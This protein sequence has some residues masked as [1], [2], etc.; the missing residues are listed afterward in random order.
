MSI[1]IYLEILPL[2]VKILLIIVPAGF[3]IVSIMMLMERIK[4]IKG[5]EEDDLSKY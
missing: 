3:I 5:G 4:E 2:V 1:G